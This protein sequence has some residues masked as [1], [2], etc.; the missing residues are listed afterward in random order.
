MGIDAEH[1]PVNDIKVDGR[2]IGG[3]GAATV[4]DSMIVAG[5]LMFGLNDELMVKVLRV[6]SEKLRAKT[7]SSAPPTTRMRSSTS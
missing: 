6:P 3:T 1:R 7:R 2:K 5:S 4:G